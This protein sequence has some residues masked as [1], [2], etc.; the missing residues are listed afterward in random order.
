MEGKRAKLKIADL[1]RRPMRQHSGTDDELRA[2]AQ[3]WLER[4]VHDIVVCPSR[5]VVDG[6]RRLAGLEL[7]GQTE[8]EVLI[9]DQE[10]DDKA[11]LEVG[12]TTAIH[13]ADLSGFDKFQACMYLLEL[14][15]G[16]QNQD[17]A[18]CVKL[19][20]SMVTKLLSPSKCVAEVVEALR[21]NKIAISD[22]YEISKAVD[23][24]GQLRLL[25]LKNAGASREVLAV[26]GRKQRS[27]ATPAV[28]TNKIKVPLVSG[29]VVTVSGDEITLE[30]AIEA[31][32]EA[33]K[34][35]KAAVAKGL[36]AKT[37]MNVWR[38]IAAAS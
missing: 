38:D 9:T 6:H 16:W 15:P 13:R 11:I 26:Q 21:E 25:A 1:K 22:A 36:N 14:N 24:E 34:Q 29:P 33:V 31:A 19:D 18:K 37:A 4:P 10:L 8:V 3:S 32:G 27:A 30:E 23:R 2:L 17:L 7:L 35:M 5:K 20:P 12:L 28:R